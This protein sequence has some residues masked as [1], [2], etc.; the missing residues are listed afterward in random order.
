[1]MLKWKEEY[2]IGIELIDAQHKHIFEIGN[3]AYV[4]LKDEFSLDKY[5]KIVQVIED[6]RQYTKYHFKCEEEYMLKIK[7]PDYLT[8]KTEHDDFIKKVDSFNLDKI[9]QDQD[10]YIGDLISFILGWT[11]DHILQKDKLIKISINLDL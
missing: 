2:S 8:Q 10:K 6:L 3:D 4:L 1:M 5:S 9:N 7:Y 11:L